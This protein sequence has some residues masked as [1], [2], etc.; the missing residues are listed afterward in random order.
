MLGK[1]NIVC[2]I[3]VIF[4]VGGVGGNREGYALRRGVNKLRE[5]ES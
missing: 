2:L 3:T 4:V 1:V 5:R